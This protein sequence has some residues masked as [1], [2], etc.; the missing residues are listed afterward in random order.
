MRKLQYNGAKIVF[1]TGA[2]TTINLYAKINESRYRPYIIQKI[3][4]KCIV[5]LM[6]KH[7]T[8][9][10]LEDNTGEN[11]GDLE[12]HSDFLDTEWHDSWKKSLISQTSL[13]LKA[14]LWKTMSMSIEW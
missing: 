11:L 10:L 8:I 1:S 6:V 12:C 2:G 7:K 4:S 14:A 3:N 13:K 5:E 9:Q